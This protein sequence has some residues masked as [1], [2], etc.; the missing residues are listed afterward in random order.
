MITL[1]DV[2]DPKRT[3]RLV[4]WRQTPQWTRARLCNEPAEGP[5]TYEWMN[6]TPLR[7]RVE[8]V[9]NAL[10][11]KKPWSPLV[12]DE[13]PKLTWKE[14]VKIAKGNQIQRKARI[15][16]QDTRVD[17]A[18]LL[19]LLAAVGPVVDKTLTRVAVA[20]R[21]G[22]QLDEI[23]SQVLTEVR[24][25]KNRFKFASTL[26][27]RAAYDEVAWDL[28]DRAITRHLGGSVHEDVLELLRQSYRAPV[29]D[30]RGRPIERTKGIPQ[31]SVLGPMLLNLYL[32]DFDKVI[33]RSIASLGCKC[34]R[35]S[36]DLLMVAPNQESLA[37][38]MSVVERELQ[39]LRLRVK[40]ETKG[41]R[42]LQNP[43]N[44]ARWLG[45]AFTLT[46]TWV[47]RERIEKKAAELLHNLVQGH[48]SPKA[49]E[50]V[51]EAIEGHHARV[52]HP[53]DARRAVL[54][55]RNLIKPFLDQVQEQKKGDLLSNV[56]KQIL[57][58]HPSITRSQPARDRGKKEKV[59]VQITLEG[60]ELLSKGC[61]QGWSSEDQ[62]ART[63]SGG[64]DLEPNTQIPLVDQNKIYKGKA[65]D[66]SSG[67][68]SPCTPPGGSDF[69]PKG[70][71]STSG[72]PAHQD[73][74]SG[75]GL[76]EDIGVDHQV[77]PILSPSNNGSSLATPA[78]HRRTESPHSDQAAHPGGN[79]GKTFVSV[80]AQR[81]GVARVRV[82]TAGGARVHQIRVPGAR[83]REETVLHGYR[84]ALRDRHVGDATL[85]I[86]H[87]TLI[88]QLRDGHRV[89]SP[90]LMR[91][92]ELLLEKVDRPQP[93]ANRAI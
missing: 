27:V 53:D 67:D 48:M 6:G 5:N 63:P 91:A 1:Q 90:A 30:R 12:R 93:S 44:A 59:Q 50:D 15:V 78:L 38:A 58:K 39:R 45:Y 79:H 84:L 66:W 60:Q 82:A 92:W 2:A 71:E 75:A 55:V 76:P 42:S 61:A 10:L 51:L 72:Q 69:E 8:E 83:S 18:G 21:E 46:K 22:T 49:L 4:D 28:L 57:V 35:Y 14:A 26:D 65:Q 74:S 23:L 47:P 34:W 31:G 25:P 37:R 7:A 24:D 56:R 19:A 73:G 3:A 80:E 32:T 86:K 43:Q 87:P 36:D 17:H 20:Y 29:V 11:T 40:Q 9:R 33:S 13:I 52:I 64:S 89:R 62:R 85:V 54:A 77:F 70:T 16:H 81:P 41:I 88:G 68:Q